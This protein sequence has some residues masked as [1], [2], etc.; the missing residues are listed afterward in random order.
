MLKSLNIKQAIAFGYLCLIIGG[1]SYTPYHYSFS[2]IDPQNETRQNDGGQTMSFEDDNVRFRFIPSSENIHVAIRNKTDHKIDIVRDNAEYIDYLGESHRIHYGYDYV[3]EVT[4]FTGD[5][6]LYVSPIT[7]DPDSEISG[8]VWINIWPDFGIGQ[9]RHSIT[10]DQINYL[11][12][13]FFPRY[14]FEGMGED[15]KDSTFNLILPIDFG[16][17][18]R[19][20]T[21]TFMINDVL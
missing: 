1:C 12:E 8:Y 17:Y 18:T 9:D 3:Q 11:M 5:N 16:E 2:L 6:N 7:I 10:M 13:P 14:S 4:D 15:L 21:F 20:Y 19:N